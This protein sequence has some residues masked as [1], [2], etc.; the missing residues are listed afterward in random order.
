MD[1]VYGAPEVDLDL[2]LPLLSGFFHEQ[3]VYGPTHIIHQHVNRPELGNGRRHHGGDVLMI[4]DVGGDHVY[5]RAGIHSD[6]LSSNDLSLAWHQFCDGD[7]RTFSSECVDDSAADVG[8]AASDYDVF[9][10]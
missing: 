7:L 3:P 4:G 1:A 5:H 10:L 9:T 8:P 6:Y 2:P